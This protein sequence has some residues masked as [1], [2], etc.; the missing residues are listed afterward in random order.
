MTKEEGL[1]RLAYY[2]HAYRKSYENSV[3][4]GRTGAS[5]YAAAHSMAK[6]YMRLAGLNSPEEAIA[7]IKKR[8]P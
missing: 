8:G 2:W 7:E 5:S 4:T 3:A 6:Q 1:N